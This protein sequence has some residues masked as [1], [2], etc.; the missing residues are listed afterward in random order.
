MLGLAENS[1]WS[2]AV[3]RE[4]WKQVG[5]KVWTKGPCIAIV[6][7]GNDRAEGA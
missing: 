7:I 1:L 3:K 6:N 5:C 2:V 4:E